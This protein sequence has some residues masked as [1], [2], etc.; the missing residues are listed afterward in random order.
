MPVQGVDVRA[1]AHEGLNSRVLVPF[2]GNVKRSGPA[3]RALGLGIRPGQNERADVARFV[4]EGR[5]VEGRA[6]CRRSIS[7]VY[8]IPGVNH[9]LQLVPPADLSGNAER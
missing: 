8:V 3:L 4:V 5:G 9:R 6:A 2:G 7:V 1:V